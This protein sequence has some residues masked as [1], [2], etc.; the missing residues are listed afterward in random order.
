MSVYK[1]GII[2]LNLVP[3][4]VLHITKIWSHPLSSSRNEFGK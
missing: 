1:I 4:I 3:Y 2:L